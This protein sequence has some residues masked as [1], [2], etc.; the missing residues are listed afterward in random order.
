MA[1]N[2]CGD[3]QISLL[4]FGCQRSE[5]AMINRARAPFVFHH[6]SNLYPFFTSLKKKK[7]SNTE[8][9]TGKKH[10]GNLHPSDYSQPAEQLGKG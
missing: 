6:L 1:K 7:E 5:T 2:L 8:I 4:P 10:I 9:I 3:R